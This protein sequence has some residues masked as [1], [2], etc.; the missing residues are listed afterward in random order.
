V[1]RVS[2]FASSSSAPSTR[3]FISVF[4]DFESLPLT[5]AQCFPD[6]RAKILAAVHAS[7][8]FRVSLIEQLASVNRMAPIDDAANKNTPQK[9]AEENESE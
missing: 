4:R 8:A 5:R 1:K 7:T 2:T 3:F 9:E 6:R